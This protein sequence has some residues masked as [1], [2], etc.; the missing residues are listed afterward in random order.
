MP[1]VREVFRMA[2]QKIRPDEGFVDRQLEAQ[3]RRSRNRKVGAIGLVA[4]L[5]VGVLAFVSVVLPGDGENGTPADPGRTTPEPDVATPPLG[6]QI[7]GLGGVV[8]Q[9][10]PGLPN[11]AEGLR[12]PPDESTIAFMTGGQVATIGTDGTGMR[13]LTSGD[14]ANTGDAQNAVSWSPDGTQIAYA[15][16]G[17][18]YV[19]DADG[20]NVRRLTTDPDGG[21]LP[22]LVPRRF[23]DRVL[24][25]LHHRSGRRTDRRRA[26][27]DPGGWR[28]ADPSDEQK[29]S[30]R[31]SPRGLRTASRSRTFPRIRGTF[32]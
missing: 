28:H 21:L 12:M 2:T 3:R 9:E 30:P 8:M 18:L 11:D 4:A 22:G 25:R 10:I 1:D 19:M 31:S 17:D 5:I 6:A 20:S 24:E 16:S 29:T 13:V 27:H 23:D 7:V 14:N 15:F 32:G 26:L